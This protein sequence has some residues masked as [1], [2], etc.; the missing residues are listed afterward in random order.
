MSSWNILR[1]GATIIYSSVLTRGQHAGP[2]ERMSE[3]MPESGAVWISI[4]RSCDNKIL[5][6]VDSFN[7]GRLSHKDKDWDKRK[8]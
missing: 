7:N 2:G 5:F 1:Q 4:E 6:H 8:H 3:L